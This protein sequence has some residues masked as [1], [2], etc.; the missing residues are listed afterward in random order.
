MI[1]S[2][3]AVLM[4]EHSDGPLKMVQVAKG[5]GIRLPTISAI[6]KSQMKRIDVDQ[7]ESLCA[8]FACQPGD[9]FVRE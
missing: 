5:T 1:K 6:Y 7:L 9:L 3:L 8:F 2:R 4:A